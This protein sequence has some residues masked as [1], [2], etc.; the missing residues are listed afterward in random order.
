[1]SR[2]IAVITVTL[3][4]GE[5][6]SKIASFSHGAGTDILERAGPGSPARVIR[7]VP[8]HSA[9]VWRRN[10]GGGGGGGPA[11]ASVGGRGRGTAER[12]PSRPLRPQGLQRP[13][14]WEAYWV[15]LE[16][17][18][19]GAVGA[20]TWGAACGCGVAHV[21]SVGAGPYP[22]LRASDPVEVGGY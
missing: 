14:P 8:R 13:G 2:N 10:A 5:N 6:G 7:Q 18:A 4:N 12:G 21:G 9:A 17:Y 20:V 22:A 15:E 11:V 16:A 3:A 19:T 1:M